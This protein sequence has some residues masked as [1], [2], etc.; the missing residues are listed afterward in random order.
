MAVNIIFVSL[1]TVF[2][3]AAISV[4]NVTFG[5]TPASPPTVSVTVFEK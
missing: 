2:P 3:P 1:H 5:D 4:V